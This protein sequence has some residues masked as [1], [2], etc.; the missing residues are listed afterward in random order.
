MKKYSNI[1]QQ[2]CRSNKRKISKNPTAANTDNMGKLLVTFFALLMSR[3]PGP[4]KAPAPGYAHLHVMKI[5][6]LDYFLAS[7][8]LYIAIAAPVTASK[9]V[10]NIKFVF[11][12]PNCT[13]TLS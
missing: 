12:A 1:I 9:F 5:L 3:L 2:A 4:V 6:H 10:N 8:G 13:A 11:S 7:M